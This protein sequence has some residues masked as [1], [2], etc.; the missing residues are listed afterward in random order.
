[1]AKVEQP[2]V[3][4]M[5]KLVHALLGR[6]L[7]QKAIGKSLGRTQPWVSQILSGAR[8]DIETEP[9]VLA[10]KRYAFDPMA[11]Q[12]WDEVFSPYPEVERYIEHM[13]ALDAIT[14]TQASHLRHEVRFDNGVGTFELAER[15][16]RNFIE[17]QASAPTPPDAAQVERR[18]AKGLRALPRT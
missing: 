15:A 7:S 3:A 11:P 2:A 13:L 4:A 5:K 12:A 16:H 18:A 14:P 6:G 9:I 10:R 8:K 1:M 17:E